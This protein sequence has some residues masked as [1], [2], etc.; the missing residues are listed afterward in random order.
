MEDEKKKKRERIII[1]I[2]LAKEILYLILF[3]TFEKVYIASRTS[4]KAGIGS[5]VDW[6]T[7]SV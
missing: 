3:G 5:R 4:S 6:C 1:L 2:F 7:R